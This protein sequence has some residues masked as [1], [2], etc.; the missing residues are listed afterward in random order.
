MVEDIVYS[1]NKYRETE[2]IKDTNDPSV[3]I[4]VKL[5][6]KNK[7]LYV[8]DEYVKQGMLNDEIARTINSMGYSK[9]VI[10]ADAAEQ[11]SIAE[12]KRAGIYRIKP[13]RKGVDSVSQGIQYMQQF[14][15]IVDERC[16]HTIEELE[17]YTWL[18]DKKT[19]EYINKPVDLFNH[20]IDAIRYA[21][22]T[23]M[24]G[25]KAIAIKNTYI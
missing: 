11:K 19:G 7:R 6:V 21:I 8:L 10:T 1:P 16:T 4:H 17:N 23:S 18:K 2:G 5:D 14:S 15:I 22:E 12:I 13:A 25:N 3:F 20:C 9:E 24:R